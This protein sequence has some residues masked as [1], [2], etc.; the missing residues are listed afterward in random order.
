MVIGCGVR[1]R[2]LHAVTV[3]TCGYLLYVRYMQLQSERAVTY[4]TYVTCSYNPN[5]RLLTLRTLH[6]V[7]IR[8]CGYLLY[9]RYM[10]L[11]SERAVTYFTYV[12]CSYVRHMQLR[13]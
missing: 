3:R 6:A 4:F 5:V 9:V 10:Q 1:L 13:T 7:T 12:T 8:T 11:Q 2:A